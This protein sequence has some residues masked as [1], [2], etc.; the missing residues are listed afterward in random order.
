M[1]N[2]S[3]FLM[4]LTAFVSGCTSSI[5]EE[6]ADKP[7]PN[8]SICL[9]LDGTDRRDRQQSIPEVDIQDVL[10]LAAKVQETGEGKLF[11]T[12]IDDNC[13]NNGHSYL[14]I[15]QPLKSPRSTYPKKKDYETQ[16]E[17]NKE[18]DKIMS[19]F[20]ADSIAF[21]KS[22]LERLSS[23][24]EKTQE[25]INEAYSDRV[26]KNS[27]GSDINGAISLG[28]KLLTTSNASISYLILISDCVDNVK[29][30][31]VEIPDNIQI[32]LINN[33]V[34][35]HQLGDKIKM[36]LSNLEQICETIF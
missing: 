22:R 1:K 25:I 10:N 24:R 12:F 17:Y 20:I 16:A 23:F 8:Y 9:V 5:K 28:V 14:N 7:I 21:E 18:K 15:M 6:I 13:A 33:S 36:E 31:L 34:S 26:A 19:E 11:L 27:R 35:N 3:L 30:P 4:I 32:I 2:T 29:K